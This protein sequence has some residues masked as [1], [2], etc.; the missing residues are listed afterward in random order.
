MSRCCLLA[1]CCA[2]VLIAGAGSA[3]AQPLPERFSR[4]VAEV[5]VPTRA[6]AWVLQ[7][8]TVGGFTGRGTEPV[9]LT[10]EQVDLASLH[11][12]VRQAPRWDWSGSGFS[13]MCSDCY[14]TL[15]LLT[16][17]DETDT[18][19]RHLAYWDPTTRARL[20]KEVTGL[21]DMAVARRR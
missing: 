12:A 8:I 3:A 15:L 9:T 2:G 14:S 21:Y 13:S 19:R 6:G 17:R 1:A 20:A 10:S 18:L 7:V 11:D 16:W 4:A 5:P